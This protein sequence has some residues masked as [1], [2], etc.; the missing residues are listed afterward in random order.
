MSL[1]SLDGPDD[2]LVLLIFCVSSQALECLSRIRCFSFSRSFL[3]RD[4]LPR[5]SL[6]G[7][8]ARPKGPFAS[9][10]LYAASIP[11]LRFKNLR[12]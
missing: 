7:S 2:F 9:I 3:L 8:S 4:D 10:F 6:R 12:R 11:A 5:S 1:V